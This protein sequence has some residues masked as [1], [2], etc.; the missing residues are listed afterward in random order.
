MLADERLQAAEIAVA[1][2]ATHWNRKSYEPVGREDP[3]ITVKFIMYGVIGILHA[4]QP[5]L[6]HAQSRPA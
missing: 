2:S 4:A 3:R 1:C 5:G 6:D